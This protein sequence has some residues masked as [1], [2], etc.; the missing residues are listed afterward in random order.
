MWSRA[1]LTT[2]NVPGLLL[3]IQAVQGGFFGNRGIRRYVL[4]FTRA[5]LGHDVVRAL[6]LNPSR[7]WVEEF[8][9]DIRTAPN[10]AWTTR[11]KLRE[12]TDDGAAAY[13]MTSPFEQASPT[14]SVLPSLVVESGTP[15]VAVLYDL[16]PEIV[17]VYPPSLMPA[18]RARRQLLRD[19][20]L[21]LTLSAHVR[22]EAVG[23]LG[24][25]V[26]RTAVIGAAVSEFFRTRDPGEC[27]LDLL[28]RRVPRVT[29]P[30]V[31]SVTGWQAHKN[32]EALI[33]A[34]SRVPERV[35]RA[36]QLV[37]TCPL[38]PGGQ[39]AWNDVAA[40]F[41]LAPDDVIVTG[42]VDDGV[43]RALYQQGE[44]FVLPSYEEGFGLPVLEA[45]RCGCP[46][47][48]SS[49]SSLPEVLEWEPATFPPEDVDR[50]AETIERGVL[51]PLFRADLRGVGDAAVRRHTW[52]GVAQRTIDA[53][54]RIGTSGTAHP[55]ASPRIALVGRFA[56][57][58]TP[59][60][61]AAD[62]VAA[63]LPPTWR[64]DRFDTAAPT[65][66][67]SSSSTARARRS[68]SFPVRALGRL[69]DPWGYDSIVYVVDA[70]PSREL[71]DLARAYP[72]VV[73]F[74]EQ[75]AVELV[76]GL[77]HGASAIVPPADAPVLAVD[78]GPFGR[79]PATPA[80]P[81]GLRDVDAVLAAL[82]SP[83]SPVRDAAR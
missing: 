51:D 33:E 20:D 45:A 4:G 59:T 39:A 8:P 14:D 12:L 15:I 24:I 75:P 18:Y 13:V 7:P 62:R 3:D 32:V 80:A 60:A 42:R 67:G 56:P 57:A 50:M 22:R 49:S 70:R 36:Y 30:F 71:L 19:A 77:T 61:M 41:G 44:L 25:P 65:L 53:C 28:V 48:T 29:R 26:E 63:Q 69:R 73:W 23:R 1:V 37:L 78:T 5:L 55:R 46:A 58:T 72:G 74:I 68:G 64:V 47:I 34:W 81:D 82:G 38:P 43:L 27:P 40:G 66:P 52:A 76:E 79:A 54:S 9:S 83:A 31:L 35:R 11:T 10:L 6:L 17:D 16:I 2:D 21:V